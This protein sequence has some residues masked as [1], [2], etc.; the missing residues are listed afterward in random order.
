M[1]ATLEDL[2]HLQAQLPTLL[3]DDLGDAVGQ[4]LGRRGGVLGVVHDAEAAAQVGL[5]DRVVDGEDAYRHS[6]WLSFMERRLQVA[7][8]LLNPEDSVLIV[9]IDEKEYLR[10][11]LLLEQTFPEGQIEIDDDRVERE[12]AREGL[13]VHV[14]DHQDLAARLA[15]APEHDD[16]PALV[17]CR[18][19]PGGHGWGPVRGHR[20]HGVG[21]LRRPGR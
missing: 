8:E 2:L 12:V 3:G 10:L 7:R 1:M 21:R 19:G 11:G 5:G 15:L 17:Q 4:H 13:G 20:D 6:K 14:R 18:A 16:V 9:T